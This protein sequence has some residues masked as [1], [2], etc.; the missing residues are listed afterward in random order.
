M[1]LLEGLI[2][3]QSKDGWK[4]GLWSFN[5][6]NAG[7]FARHSILLSSSNFFEMCLA[8]RVYWHIFIMTAMYYNQQEQLW[9]LMRRRFND[10]GIHK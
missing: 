3:R 6:I 7:F 9:A 2:S 1:S 4:F 8:L 10:T 5:N